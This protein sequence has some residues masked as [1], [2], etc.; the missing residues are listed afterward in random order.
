MTLIKTMK[1]FSVATL[2]ML[3]VFSTSG[4]GT[5]V[6]RVVTPTHGDATYY[7]GIQG[8]FQFLTL[9]TSHGYDITG[10]LCLITI[11]CPVTFVYSLPVDFAI[12]TVLLPYDFYNS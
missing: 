5:M 3:L 2:A 10:V 6:S 1:F 7:K 9:Q 11:I 8:T 4:C 12:D